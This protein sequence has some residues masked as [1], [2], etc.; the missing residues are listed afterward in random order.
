MR[1]IHVV[2]CV[3]TIAPAHLVAQQDESNPSA[4]ETLRAS[5]ETAPCEYRCELAV[6]GGGS[7][8]FGAALSA[9]RLGVDVILV[10]RADSL[11]GNSVRSG[12]NCWE[13]GSGGTGIPFDLYLRLRE[14]P[15]AIGVYS[16]GR[17]LV[18]YDPQKEPY[19]YPGGESVID[20]SRTYLDTLRRCGTRGLSADPALVRELW[21]GLPFEPQA[22]AQTMLAM[23][24]ETGHCR[25]LFNTAFVDATMADQRIERISLSDGSTLV[26][27]YYIDATG[28]GVVCLRAGCRMMSGQESRE[29]FQEPDAP[30]EATSRVNGVSLLYRAT[31]VADPGIE[32]LPAN[33]PSECWWAGSFPVAAINHYPNGDLNINMLPTMDGAEFLRNGYGKAYAECHRRVLAHWHNL[34]ANYAEFEKFRLSWIAPALGIRESRR[35]VGQYVLTEHDLLA[36]I[37][38]QTH[39]DIVCLADHAMDT[40]GS[41]ARGIGELREPYGVPYRCLVPAGQ[42]NLLIA[43]RAAS[44]SSL[45]ASSC[46]LS[47]TMMQLGQAAGT[48]V[49]TAR[50][51]KVELPDVPPDQL[52]AALRQQQVQLEHPLSSQL[53]EHVSQ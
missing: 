24:N 27:D 22:M 12:V 20:R 43:C 37:S 29:T 45:A 51:L 10:E 44:F 18:W 49:A 17:H 42:R 34:Q 8:G 52:R 35:V 53:Q 38:R 30:E 23:L 46:R 48:A 50:Q 47:R 36:G 33:V 32:P 3:L 15:D 19:R 28:D 14:Q 21:H 9:A 39:P 1:C 11:G 25:T 31:P 4:G 16:F 13:M 40:H 41:H 6:I 5:T 26:A 2:I 7:G